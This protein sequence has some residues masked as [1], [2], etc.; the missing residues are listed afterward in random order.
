MKDHNYTINGNISS[1][2]YAINSRFNQILDRLVNHVQNFGYNGGNAI[3]SW[4]NIP[5]TK[6]YSG[7][8]ATKR[9]QITGNTTPSLHSKV[10][11]KLQRFGLT[12]EI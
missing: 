11:N 3:Q 2:T 5:Y 9:G 8:N 12:T 1:S 4:D 7:F 6:G 10:L